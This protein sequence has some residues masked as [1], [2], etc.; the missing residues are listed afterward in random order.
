MNKEIQH[1]LYWELLYESYGAK[2]L[3]PL[4]GDVEAAGYFKI[5]A[6]CLVNLSIITQVILI[7]STRAGSRHFWK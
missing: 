5:S 7:I 1:Q 6:R 2:G 3:T 4:P